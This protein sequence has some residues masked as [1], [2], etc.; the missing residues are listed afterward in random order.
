[1]EEDTVGFTVGEGLGD[2]VGD[3]VGSFVSMDVATEGK[4]DGFDVKLI[5]SIGDSDPCRSS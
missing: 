2:E 3:F 5:E 4:G 1:M